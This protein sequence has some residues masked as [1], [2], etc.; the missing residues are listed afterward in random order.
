MRVEIPYRGICISGIV[1]LSRHIASIDK[2][3]C[4]SLQNICNTINSKSSNLLISFRLM[5]YSRQIQALI[6]MDM[7]ALGTQRP[8]TKSRNAVGRT[9]NE[10]IIIFQWAGQRPLKYFFHKFFLYY[11]GFFAAYKNCGIENCKQTLNITAPLTCF[12][13]RLRR[14]NSAEFLR[15]STSTDTNWPIDGHI[16]SMAW[17]KKFIYMQK[18]RM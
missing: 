3:S 8:T 16:Y 7:P 1:L 5:C 14:M 6:G 2:R 15:D 9:N 18:E 4:R 17:Q 12:L 13:L 11:N 10:S